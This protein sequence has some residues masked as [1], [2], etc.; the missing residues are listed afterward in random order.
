MN[1]II[2]DANTRDYKEVALLSVESYREYSQSLTSENW[3]KMKTNLSNVSEVAN[4]AKLIV[5]EQNHK[6][7]GSV[8]YCRPGTSSSRLFRPEWASLRMLAVLPN[9]RGQ[10]IGRYLSEECIQRAKLDRAE[11]VGLHTSELMISARKL[12]D[13]LGFQQDIELPRSLG[14]RYW[15][16][17]LRLT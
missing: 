11:V 3:N 12:Y 10:K 1:L 8:F 2:R 15:R 17:V 7:V 6:L 16:Y 9:Y 4:Q 5:A 14:I 13:K